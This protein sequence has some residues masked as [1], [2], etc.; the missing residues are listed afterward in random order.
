MPGFFILPKKVKKHLMFIRKYP[1][2]LSF[3]H[4]MLFQ[5]ILLGILAVTNKVLFK[6]FTDCR[7]TI[8][9]K[10]WKVF[11]QDLHSVVLSFFKNPRVMLQRFPPTH[12]IK[13]I[14]VLIFNK[15]IW[16]YFTKVNNRFLFY[17]LKFDKL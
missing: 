11:F 12:Y 14:D 13:V 3:I 1:M 2:L 5:F 10:L 17:L 15:I 16:N 9:I 7:C 6:L 8:V 4:P